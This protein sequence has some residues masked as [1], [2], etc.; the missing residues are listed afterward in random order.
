MK[1]IVKYDGAYPNL[2]SGTLRVFI[3]GKEWIFPDYCMSSGGNVTFD[4]NWSENVTRGRWSINAWPKDFPEDLK[5]NVTD[6][7]NSTV[8]WGCCG[9]CV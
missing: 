9:G 6:E 4:K 3:D 2:C 1:I 8:D 7:I 5:D